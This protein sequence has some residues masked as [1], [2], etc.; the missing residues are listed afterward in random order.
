MQLRCIWQ[1]T[2]WRIC[3]MSIELDAWSIATCGLLMETERQ[4]RR[5]R[6]SL[7]ATVNEAGQCNFRVC[8]KINLCAWMDAKWIHVCS[9][10]KNGRRNNFWPILFDDI[11]FL[12]LVRRRRKAGGEEGDG[13]RKHQIGNGIIGGWMKKKG[14]YV[15]TV[16][17]APSIFVN[18]IR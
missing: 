14:G 10:I 8:V 15:N 17:N 6:L 18:S 13:E 4:A 12:S 16:V 5:E 7:S 9:R 3:T 1:R 11:F 2:T